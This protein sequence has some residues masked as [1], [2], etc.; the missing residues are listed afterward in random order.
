[1]FFPDPESPIIDILYRWSVRGQ[2]G[3]CCFIVSS[4][5]SELIIFRLF[6]YIVTFNL[7]FF[8]FCLLDLCLFHMHMFQSNQLITFFILYHHLNL[9]QPYS[10]FSKTLCLSFLNLW[11][12]FNINLLFFMNSIW[13]FY[14]HK[15]MYINFIFF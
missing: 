9:K 14:D 6:Y 8:I 13:S 1:M 15:T 2:F 10:F 3:L 4:V 5:T 7:F 12:I 11:Y